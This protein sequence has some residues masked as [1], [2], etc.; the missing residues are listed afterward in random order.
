VTDRDAL[1][2]AILANPD[3]DTPRLVYA[4]WCEDHG[5]PDYA[6]FIRT[7]VELARVPEWDPLW[8]RTWE[9]DRDAVTGSPYR[10]RFPLPPVPPSNLP[11]SGPRF[12]RG[13]PWEAGEFTP[14]EFAD[15]AD[16]LFAAAPIQAVEL[17]SDYRAPPPDVGPLADCPH[18]ARVR[19]LTFS[20]SRLPA[21][22][23]RRLAGSPHTAGLTDLGFAFAGIAADGAVE[24]LRSSLLP[25]LTRLRLEHVDHGSPRPLDAIRAAG[26]PYL[27][28]SLTIT[29]SPPGRPNAAGLFDAPLFRGLVELN[30]SDHRL[31]PD[32][33]AALAASPAAAGLESLTGWKTAPGVPGVRALA[34][35][36]ALSGLRRLDLR[37]CDLGPV[38]VKALAG[39][40]H[41]RN[42]VDLD[43]SG[44][45]VGDAGAVA[46]AESPYLRN[47]VRL[48]LM[49]GGIGNRGAVALLESPVTANLTRLDIYDMP[50]RSRVADDVRK[51]LKDRF[52][53]RVHV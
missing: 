49:H 6:R 19:R 27:L 50:H 35:A 51:R 40:P 23:V 21:E 34:G 26:G 37:S 47:L 44:N 46:L 53:N 45:T 22:A 13:F 8:I 1:Y 29:E 41:L 42:L 36:P 30:L 25:R 10:H 52:G 11:Y 5:D 20:L 16:A 7:Q 17:R 24:L 18:L 33:F 32:G 9:H 15:R 39:S 3:D 28:R 12:R 14:A 38:A 2:P 43:L 4:D 48:D 31:G